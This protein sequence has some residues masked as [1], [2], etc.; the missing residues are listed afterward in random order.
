MPIAASLLAGEL[1]G[2][3]GDVPA[4]PAHELELVLARLALALAAG[5]RAGAVRAAAG[6]LVEAHLPCRRVGEADHDHALVEEGGDD[7]EERRLLPAVLGR[8]RG[9][10]AADLADE[11]VRRPEPAGLVPEIRHLRG[12][13]PEPRR[14]ADDDRVVV[15]ELGGRR[16]RRLL[17][18][19]RAG[20][21]GDLGRHQLRDPLHVDLGAGATRPLGGRLSHALD[22]SVGAVIEDEDLRHGVSGS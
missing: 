12:D 19:L 13:A 18:E 9:E 21:L 5:N 10:G 15:G 7:R 17:V 1:R 11:G 8:G 16:D 14:R 22:V 3:L 6:D 2:D 20:L 4:L